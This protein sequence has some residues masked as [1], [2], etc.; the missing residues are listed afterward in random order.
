M[1]HSPGTDYRSAGHRRGR[2]NTRGAGPGPGTWRPGPHPLSAERTPS[3]EV[4]GYGLRAS[5]AFSWLLAA[6]DLTVLCLMGFGLSTQ[7]PDPATTGTL[8][9]NT[10]NLNSS[11]PDPALRGGWAR[12]MT[13]ACADKATRVAVNS[14]VFRSS[15]HHPRQLHR[16]DLPPHG[17]HAACPRSPRCSWPHQTRP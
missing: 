3:A 10:I 15:G 7:D 16:D 4:S 6:M 5:K 14:V 13:W 1:L 9:G 12:R 17:A 8:N 11:T 2:A